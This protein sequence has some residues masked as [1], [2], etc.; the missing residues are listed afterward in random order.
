M[1]SLTVLDHPIVNHKLAMLRDENTSSPEF[2]KTL[3]ELGHVISW[4][5]F[6]HLDVETKKLKLQ[7]RKQNN[8]CSPR[9]FRA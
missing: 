5:V 4:P 3:L 9:H 8:G 1:N 6:T 2:R 7:W